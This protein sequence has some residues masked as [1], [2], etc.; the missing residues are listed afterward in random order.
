MGTF[1]RNSDNRP[2]SLADDLRA[3]T[4]EQL[5]T[6]LD[7]RSDLLHPVP[8]DLGQLAVRA[9]TS[10]SVNAAL[11]TL[12]LLQLKVAQALAGLP[13]PSS[14]DDVHNGLLRANNYDAERVDSALDHLHSLGLVWGDATELHL[15]RVAREAFGAYPCG[16]AQSF[17]DSRRNVRGYAENPER[18]M[19]LLESG[20]SDA[21]TIMMQMLWETPFGTMRNA[22]RVIRLDNVKS[23]LDWL[24]AHELLVPVGDS[25]V[26]IPREVALALR[27]G[28]LLQDLGDEDIAHDIHSVDPQRADSLGVQ[29]GL[30]FIRLVETI[31]EEWSIEPPSQLRGGGLAL[32][33]L[34]HACSFIK[35]DEATTALVLEVAYAAK[36]LNADV[37]D[38]WLPTSTYDRWLSSDDATRWE[39][40]AVA[41]RDMDRAPHIV[42]G[43]TS[44]RINPLSAAV[45]RTFIRHLRS[46]VLKMLSL[47]DSGQALHASAVSRLYDWNQ[48]RKASAM[49]TEA[50]HALAREAELLGISAMG[51]LTSF[52]RELVEGNSSHAILAKQ[53]PDPIDHIIVQSDLTALAPGRLPASQRRTMAVIAD[54]ESTG[55]ATTYRFTE[56]S[57]RRGLDQGQSA[58]DIADF[59]S[60]LS[61]TPLPQPLTYLIDDVARRHGILRV[62][63]ASVYLRCDDPQ[64]INELQVD[65]RIASLKL[66]QLAEGIVVSS[67]PPDVVL[68]KL[69]AAGYAPVA[70]SAEGTVL[71]HRPDAKRTT[72]RAAAPAVSVS[73]VST[74]FVRAAVKALRAGERAGDAKSTSTR[75]QTSRMT[76]VETMTVLNQALSLGQEIWIGYADKGGNTTERIIEP[77]SITAGFLTAFD[78]RS[79]EVR[80]FTISRITGAEQLTS[81]H[82]EGT[83]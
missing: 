56:S 60:T 22:N 75:Q 16:L 26:V 19:S 45:D 47:L 49:R 77:L 55:V 21:H 78:T 48:P 73:N 1:T 25:T 27:E 46:A 36:L 64:L 70:E 33:D 13:D 30:D 6:M 80:T 7:V 17:A 58:R 20:P 72:P 66:R 68:E 57:I 40:L 42:G 37:H 2:R 51:A 31:L 54:V 3:R 52:G 41:W 79:G 81:A 4:D 35:S 82:Q 74:R 14:S 5:T 63:V 83:A 67:S 76:T 59:L 24:L 69:R 18:V 39:T 62:G 28:Q 50:I 8:T 43:T 34:T 53:L 61:K 65:R 29:S 38:G 23:P 44:E 12:T 10:P 15:V 71:I 11:D 9:T 32:R